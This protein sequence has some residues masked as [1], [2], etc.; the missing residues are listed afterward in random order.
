MCFLVW[1]TKPLSSSAGIHKW[2][3]VW[4]L[5]WGAAL[6]TSSRQDSW[7]GLPG[8]G[9]GQLVWPTSST[10]AC[11]QAG[12]DLYRSGMLPVL[13]EARASIQMKA[14]GRSQ[15][16]EGGPCEQ[17]HRESSSS[18]L[19]S[20]SVRRMGSATPGERDTG[21][22]PPLHRPVT[23][24]APDT[25]GDPE[26]QSEG[27]SVGSHQAGQLTEPGFQKKKKKKKWSSCRGAV[28]TNPTRNHVVSGSIPCLAQWVKDPVLP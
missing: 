3:W 13:T 19:G 9:V 28:E 14:A 4:I 24:K 1:S 23:R 7:Q 18:S 16:A 20:S 25:S 12:P 11:S 17:A 21:S 6:T 26:G 8:T 5:G 27:R 10:R 15:R 22:R 2:W